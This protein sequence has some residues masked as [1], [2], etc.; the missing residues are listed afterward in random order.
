VTFEN[1]GEPAKLQK[2][3]TEKK[4]KKRKK[5]RK[6]RNKEKKK[7]KKGKR[8]KEKKKKRK[9]EKRKKGKRREKIFDDKPPGQIVET[10][11]IQN[12]K[13]DQMGAKTS[14]TAAKLAE[15]GQDGAKSPKMGERAVKILKGGKVACLFC[16]SPILTPCEARQSDWRGTQW[17][18]L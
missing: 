14:D 10:F 16:R 13:N 15:T 12:N 2:E 18:P 8:K 17:F 9:E 4:E 3:E 7:N 5:N 1:S 6:K 11:S